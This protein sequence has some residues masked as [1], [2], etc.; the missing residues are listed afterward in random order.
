MKKNSSKKT[1]SSKRLTSRAGDRW[2]IGM[3]LGDKTSRY[4]VLNGKGEVELEDSVATTRGAVTK[5]FQ[6]LAACRIAIEV[7]GH[8]PW[9]SRLL[10]E[11]GHEVIVAN[12]RK[13][14]LISASSRRTTG[15]MRGCWRG[16]REWIRSCWGRSSTGAKP[17]NWS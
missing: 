8:S 9:I 13:V 7:G 17:R 12:A 4:C 16:W 14:Q 2:T 6:G 11:M 3:D 10:T 15:W 5:K 1:R